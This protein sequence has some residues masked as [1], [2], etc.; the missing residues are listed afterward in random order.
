MQGTYANPDGYVLYVKRKT[1]LMWSNFL[2]LGVLGEPVSV[3]VARRLHIF[4]A[5]DMM[6]ILNV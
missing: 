4:L 5:S 1:L 6:N 3:E 2:D